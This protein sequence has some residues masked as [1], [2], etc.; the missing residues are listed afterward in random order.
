MERLLNIPVSV[1]VTAVLVL[2]VP[3]TTTSEPEHF[4]PGSLHTQPIETIEAAP[5]VPPEEEKKDVEPEPE[6]RE[7]HEEETSRPRTAEED[8]KATVMAACEGT[9]TDWKVVY[10]IGIHES[11]HWK[12]TPGGFNYWGRKAKSG[13]WM[14]WGSFEEAA[15]DQCQ[16]IQRR[17]LERGL[18]T[19]AQIG[20]VYAE[21]PG[22]SKK[23]ERY[24]ANL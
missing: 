22:W 7:V 13:G 19:I 15:K 3:S 12:H 8:R 21:D 2:F 14:R 6:V 24:M 17:Y 1:A 11:G 23:V 18:T 16:Y 5:A 10:A 20:S 9:K 4:M